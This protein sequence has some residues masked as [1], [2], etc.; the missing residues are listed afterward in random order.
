VAN[1]VSHCGLRHCLHINIQASILQEV[2]SFGDASHRV[3][4]Y[5]YD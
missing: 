2:M 1:H 4:E 3:I 5:E